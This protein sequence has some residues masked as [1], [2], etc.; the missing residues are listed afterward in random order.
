MIK[1]R[2]IAYCLIGLVGAVTIVSLLH[3]HKR[4]DLEHQIAALTV[5]LQAL[6]SKL[7][8]KE[9]EVQSQKQNEHLLQNQYD[10]VKE[11]LENRTRIATA[12]ENVL[13]GERAPV[14]EPQVSS[15]AAKLVHDY[16]ENDSRVEQ[17][18]WMR[19]DPDN[20][21]RAV[22]EEHALDETIIVKVFVRDQ[23]GGIS[24]PNLIFTKVNHSW[25]LY[26]TD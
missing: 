20:R 19:F 22:R 9:T 24:D 5:E 13:F 10:T 4:N 7:A 16:F 8:E 23:N 21:S 1:K 6:Q 11:Q 14:I 17:I 2:V 25:Q 26:K 12:N 15:E 18:L 3:N